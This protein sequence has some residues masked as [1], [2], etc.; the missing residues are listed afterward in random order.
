MEL[1]YLWVEKYK[2]I[3][4]Q[5]F[6]FSPRFT[7]KYK[8]GVLDIKPKEHIENFFADNINVTAVVGENGSGKSSLIEM[9][10]ETLDGFF[11][12]LSKT[13]EQ[14]STKTQAE[15][16]QHLYFAETIYFILADASNLY[17]IGKT[18]A[19][20]EV[21]IVNNTRLLCQ[22]KKIEASNLEFLLNQCEELKKQLFVLH[23]DYSF[24]CFRP[25]VREKSMSNSSPNSLVNIKELYD[26]NELMIRC[27]PKKDGTDGN[28]NILTNFEYDKI[29]ILESLIS[30]QSSILSTNY[31]NPSQIEFRQKLDDALFEN[32]SN[33]KNIRESNLTTQKY[34]KF[35]IYYSI[36]HLIFTNNNLKE[37]RNE[38]LNLVETCESFDKLDTQIKSKKEDILKLFDSSFEQD[39]TRKGSRSPS[40]LLKMKKYFEYLDILNNS[41]KAIESILEHGRTSIKVKI[42]NINKE[43][44]NLLTKIPFDVF[45]IFI[46]DNIKNA[47]YNDLSNGEK[48]AL[49]IRFYIEDILNNFEQKNILVIL[50]EP[51]N[52][53]HPEWQKKLLT[54]LIEVFSNREKK[55]HFIISTH[56]PFILSDLMKQNIIFLKNGENISETVNI[57]PFGANIHTLLSHV[58]FMKDGLMGEFAKG[59]INEVIALLKKE[60]LSKNEI[61]TC[62][63]IISIIGEPFLQTKLEQMYNEKFGL[64]D[65]LEELQKQQEKINLKIEQLKK[66]KSENVKS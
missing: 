58:F 60:Q 36:V 26:E 18:K 15:Y 23:Y 39:G 25:Y 22:Q 32:F 43:N 42:Q 34:L 38:V 46:F 31:F 59:K 62:K 24:S 6:N 63:L 14:N 51:A 12:F 21:T 27:V 45:N 33:L 35:L 48:S 1:V 41:E 37:K 19:D 3:E 5:G 17:I 30:N 66:Q 40:K 65:E 16:I 64:D 8:D 61:K 54:Y 56:S 13:Q 11:I 52:D 49:R 2:N 4:K 7:C 29:K 44:V 57:N 10:I 20:T 50:D 28:D 47:E 53:M 9:L 55:F